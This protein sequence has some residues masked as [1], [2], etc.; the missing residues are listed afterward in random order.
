MDTCWN[1]LEFL[2]LIFPI[3]NFKMLNLKPHKKFIVQYILSLVV[4]LKSS[5]L[6]Y[7]TLNFLIGTKFTD[8][9]TI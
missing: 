1:L 4:F 6:S 2:F 9:I 8:K 5:L 7:L 3:L